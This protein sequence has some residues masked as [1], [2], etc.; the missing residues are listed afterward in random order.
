VAWLPA[1]NAPPAMAARTS[2]RIHAPFIAGE[3]TRDRGV[4]V[5]VFPA[6]LR[7]DR[8]L[9]WGESWGAELSPCPISGTRS[10]SAGAVFG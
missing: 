2:G 5:R 3:I 8:M 9:F 10:H 6:L 7:A 4:R 1:P